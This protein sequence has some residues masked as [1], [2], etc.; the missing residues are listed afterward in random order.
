MESRI[1]N[2]VSFTAKLN[3]K[4]LKNNKTRWKNIADEFERQTL[5]ETNDTLVLS[6]DTE[7]E[8]AKH[9]GPKVTTPMSKLQEIVLTEECTKK[10]MELSDSKIA[11]KLAEIL[12]IFKKEIKTSGAMNR[13]FD[14]THGSNNIDKALVEKTMN[15]LKAQVKL[16]TF[17]S[18]G[19]DKI[20]RDGIKDYNSIFA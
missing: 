10:L 3:V 4:A 14:V 19:K 1:N 11:K 12:K 8:I 5:K 13:L 20:L 17:E 15:A 16:D 7:L 2:N 18:L 9:Y 6:N